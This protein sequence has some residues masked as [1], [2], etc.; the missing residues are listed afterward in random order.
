MGTKQ[1]ESE[2][3]N[4]LFWKTNNGKKFFACKPAS[5]LRDLID[6]L[7][8]SIYYYLFMPEEK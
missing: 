5:L 3:K 8:Q 7:R 4:A 6:L 1:S 2:E